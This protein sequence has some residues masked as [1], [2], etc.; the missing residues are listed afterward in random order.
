MFT[1][2]EKGLTQEPLYTRAKIYDDENT[3]GIETR[4]KAIPMEVKLMGGQSNAMAIARLVTSPRQWET[5]H[6]D[7]IYCFVCIGKFTVCN[8]EGG[9]CE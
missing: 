5:F 9:Y 7:R 3:R 6:L 2:L 4:P 8:K 1:N